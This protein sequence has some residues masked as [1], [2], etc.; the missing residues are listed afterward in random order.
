MRRGRLRYRQTRI[1]TLAATQAPQKKCRV[2]FYLR[3][4]IR[5]NEQVPVC[6]GKKC[7]FDAVGGS[8]AEPDTNLRRDRH[9][10]PEKSVSFLTTK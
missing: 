9:P 6:L 3:E 4:S 8:G 1:G 10:P 7:R 5:L 2:G